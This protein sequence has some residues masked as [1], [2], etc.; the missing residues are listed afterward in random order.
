MVPL[1][2]RTFLGM[3]ATPLVGQAGGNAPATRDGVVWTQQDAAPGS[4]A[5]SDI[6]HNPWEND[7]LS[8]G[9]TD[10][11][12]S[13]Q[14]LLRGTDRR[15]RTVTTHL[16]DGLGSHGD[17]L[18]HRDSGIL[19]AGVD[20]QTPLVVHLS[21]MDTI[22]W[23]RT[24]DGTVFG[25]VLMASHTDSTAVGWKR[26]NEQAGSIVVGVDSHGEERWRQT[27]EDGYIRSLVADGD[28]FLAVGLWGY[29]EAS[30]WAVHLAPDGTVRE[31]RAYDSPGDG[32]M[33]AV[34]TGGGYVLAGRNSTIIWLEFRN[35]EWSKEWSR[36]FD[37]GHEN[38]LVVTDLLQRPDG[39][40]VLARDSTSTYLIRTDNNGE[41]RWTATYGPSDQTSTESANRSNAFIPLPDDEYVLAGATSDEEQTDWNAW[42]ARVGQP[43]A[44]TSVE[45]PPPTETRTRHTTTPS[46]TQTVQRQTSPTSKTRRELQSPETTE[47][48]QTTAPG[49][50]FGAIVAALAVGGSAWLRQRESE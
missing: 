42:S 1:S 44:V 29:T 30:G 12:G 26:G 46:G 49:F 6:I 7:Y 40:A 32:P 2:R 48:T 21:T 50:G 31:R 17:S 20:D 33:A 28:G 8:V 34:V 16:G 10:S 25:P 9:Y 39:F 14:T 15:G 41:E 19:L 38:D 11:D 13:K 27:L 4:Q 36:S 37:V 47:S 43:S 5:L 22:T 35:R 24:Y 3:M 18:A 23:R 45:T